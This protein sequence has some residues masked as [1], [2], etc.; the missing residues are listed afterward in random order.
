[1]KNFIDIKSIRSKNL[2][3]ILDDAKKRKSKRLTT[4]LINKES[5]VK[6]LASFSVFT[7]TSACSYLPFTTEP[8]IT[9]IDENKANI[10]NSL[11]EYNRVIKGDIIKG[12]SCAKKEPFNKVSIFL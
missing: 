4:R 8:R 2:R 5:I 9:E 10:P 12:I 7:N 11:G 6:W 3:K 1:M